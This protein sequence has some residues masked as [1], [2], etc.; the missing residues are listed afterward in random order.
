MFVASTA[1]HVLELSFFIIL[2]QNIDTVTAERFEN[3]GEEDSIKIETEQHY[4]HLVQT[5]KCEQGVS[6]VCWCVL[7]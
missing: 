6:V 4:I 2:Q 1:I 7:W 3:V 5:V